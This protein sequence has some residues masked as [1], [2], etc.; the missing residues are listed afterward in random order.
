MANKFNKKDWINDKQFLIF[1]NN[2]N[3]KFLKQETYNKC[4]FECVKCG[5]KW[6]TSIDVI[7]RSGCKKCASIILQKRFQM[8]F[9]KILEI[10]KSKNI[11][12][13][14]PKEYK[15]LHQK[16]MFKCNKCE[17]IWISEYQNLVSNFRIKLGHGQCPKCANTQRKYNHILTKIKNRKYINEIFGNQ[18]EY[19]YKVT[20]TTKLV[21][22]YFTKFISND[23]LNIDHICSVKTCFFY[24]IPIWITSSPVNLQQLKFKDN[25]KKKSKCHISP[26][27]LIENFNKWIINNPEYVI[28]FIPDHISPLYPLELID[29]ASSQLKH[30]IDLIPYKNG[31]V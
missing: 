13:L 30:Q 5:K 4:Y 28:M 19:R 17:Y 18:S 7:K 16:E 10:L 6:I 20:K 27:Q 24:N 23:D 31:L 8:S 14:N 11:S 9:E 22:K 3:I 25:Q 12:V 29:Q 1:L 2:K 15:N 26:K 21:N